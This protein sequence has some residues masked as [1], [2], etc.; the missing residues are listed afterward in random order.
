MKAYGIVRRIDDLGRIVIPKEIRKNYNIK[1]G[2]ALEITTSREGILLTP[3]SSYL[4][5]TEKR[6]WADK[7]I[8]RYE[9]TFTSVFVVGKKTTVVF[10]DGIS[11]TAV[12]E[13]EDTFDY[14]VGVAVAICHRYPDAKQNAPYNL[15]H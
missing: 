9:K 12:C 6:E 5:D 13:A 10:A 3:C 8:K 4:D 15:F 2:D 1:E 7:V 14:A 11:A